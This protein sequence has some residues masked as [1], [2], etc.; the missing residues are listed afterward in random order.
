MLGEVISAESHKR[1]PHLESPSQGCWEGISEHFVPWCPWTFKPIQRAHQYERDERALIRAE[2]INCSIAQATSIPFWKVETLRVS[3][4]IFMNLQGNTKNALKG[5]LTGLQL[6]QLSLSPK[7]SPLPSALEIQG[8]HGFPLLVSFLLLLSFSHFGAGT[9]LHSTDGKP[10]LSA[11][12][13][14]MGW[15]RWPRTLGSYTLS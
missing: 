9:S 6:E 7:Q 10:C 3:D 15:G 12:A 1:R 11:P 13:M 2:R 8:K 5:S 4:Q 14:R